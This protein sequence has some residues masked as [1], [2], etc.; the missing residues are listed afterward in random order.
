[1][2]SFRQRGIWC[3]SMTKNQTNNVMSFPKTDALCKSL[4]P[5]SFSK[6]LKS[7]RKFLHERIGTRVCSAPVPWMRTEGTRIQMLSAMY[8]PCQHSCLTE[9]HKY[10]RR[11]ATVGWCSISEEQY[12]IAFKGKCDKICFC[13]EIWDQ[14]HRLCVAVQTE[15]ISSL[16]TK[17]LQSKQLK[18]Y[19]Q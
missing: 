10:K 9:K 15:E 4:S 19:S 14:V 18:I 6:G 7:W 5:T 3:I 2:H 13:T 11:H 12:W 1:M 8:F 17:S 16:K